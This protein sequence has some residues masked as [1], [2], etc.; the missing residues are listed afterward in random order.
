MSS[1]HHG[2]V[3][4]ETE[5][6]IVELG[7]CWQVAGQTL[8]PTHSLTQLSSGHGL[9]SQQTLSRLS[10]L[11]CGACIWWVECKMLQLTGQPAGSQPVKYPQ[12]G[13]QGP[14]EV[15]PVVRE[16]PLALNPFMPLSQL[17]SG[18]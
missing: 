18:A 6:L 11:Q 4:T 8:L 13:V 3:V 7:K 5:W 1:R 14:H 12:G 16:P 2:L 17:G 9:A 10:D 15:S